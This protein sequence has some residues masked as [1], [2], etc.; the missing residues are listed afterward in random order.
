MII[1]H[2]FRTVFDVFFLCITDFSILSSS[3]VNEILY[4][5]GLAIRITAVFFSISRN[6]LANQQYLTIYQ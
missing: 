6:D 2:L 1:W 3:S 4:F 5:L